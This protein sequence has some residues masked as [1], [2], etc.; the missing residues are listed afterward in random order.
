VAVHVQ[1]LVAAVMVHAKPAPPIWRTATLPVELF[2][3]C[4]HLQRALH[5]TRQGNP[6]MVKLGMHLSCGIPSTA[7]AC[8][9]PRGC[10]RLCKIMRY[11]A[12]PCALF[13]PPMHTR[14]LRASPCRSPWLPALSPSLVPV[15]QPHSD[16]ARPCLPPL[17]RG[18]LLLV[19]E[20]GVLDPSR[21]GMLG[22]ISRLMAAGYLE[23]VFSPEDIQRIL[24]P[25]EATDAPPDPSRRRPTD[26]SGAQERELW[27]QFLGRCRSNVHVVL[28]LMPQWDALLAR[29]A[30]CPGL[31]RSTVSYVDNWDLAT[32]KQVGR[33]SGRDCTEQ[34][35][36]LTCEA[37][38]AITW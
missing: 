38:L 9:M 19:S 31:F 20:A 27:Q 10:P 2:A 36:T 1:K 30:A 18:T 4:T 11:T 33:L 35:F 13:G 12:V 16:P 14:W 8:P 22:D 37:L 34:T 5:I 15:L 32:C 24:H 17:L 6:S 29:A 28:C 26:C 7:P 21:L 3:N 23:A 25:P